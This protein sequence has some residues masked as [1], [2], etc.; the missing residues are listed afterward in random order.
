MPA[1][2]YNSTTKSWIGPDG[3]LYYIIGSVDTTALACDTCPITRGTQFASGKSF[4]VGQYRFEMLT[5]G[6][7]RIKDTVSGLNLWSKTAFG[8][9][10]Y[11]IYQTDGNICIYDASNIVKWCA[12]TQNIPSTTMTISN[13]KLALKDSSGTIVHVVSS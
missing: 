2:K 9:G 6:Q 11:L 12:Y 7:A 1:N 3:T 4:T 8:A 5:N 10:S 13:G